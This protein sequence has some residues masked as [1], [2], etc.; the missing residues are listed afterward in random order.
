M[1]D[2]LL[3][4]PVL[5]TII[6]VAIVLIAVALILYFLVFK[7]R[8]KQH[9]IDKKI[10]KE[11]KLAQMESNK[12]LASEVFSKKND[13]KSKSTSLTKKDQEDIK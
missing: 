13:G 7:E 12:A 6:I 1:L 3:N 11:N 10:E 9:F 2:S 8:I 5:F 4:N